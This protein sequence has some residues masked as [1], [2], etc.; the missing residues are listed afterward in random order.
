MTK[1]TR[2]I[3]RGTKIRWRIK[4]SK[5]TNWKQ[6]QKAG[7]GGPLVRGTY[8]DGTPIVRTDK[9]NKGRVET[10]DGNLMEIRDDEG[11][12]LTLHHDYHDVK[13][14]GLKKPKKKK[15]K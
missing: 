8:P 10:V 11:S 3:P 13:F 7:Y 1:E 15:K 2:I 4:P 14:L 6:W 12:F 5:A 9:W